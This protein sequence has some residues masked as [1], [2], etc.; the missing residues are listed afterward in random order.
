MNKFQ[1]GKTYKQNMDNINYPCF[2]L[3]LII[4]MI[5]IKA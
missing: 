4:L 1:D 3:I 2:V 5:K